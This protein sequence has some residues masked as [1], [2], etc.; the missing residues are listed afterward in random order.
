[1]AVTK[2]PDWITVLEW[3]EYGAEGITFC[4]GEY[5]YWIYRDTAHPDRTTLHEERSAC[6]HRMHPERFPTKCIALETLGREP[7]DD[8]RCYHPEKA[9]AN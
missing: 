5:Q 7:H 9:N 3:E 4:T 8:T 6:L 1:M 2:L